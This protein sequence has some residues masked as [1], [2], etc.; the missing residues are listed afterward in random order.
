MLCPLLSLVL[1]A[2]YNGWEFRK[3][4]PK[5]SNHKNRLKSK[6][7]IEFIFCKESAYLVQKKNQ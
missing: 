3:S 1:Q 5:N 2:V 7:Q 6:R 4:T